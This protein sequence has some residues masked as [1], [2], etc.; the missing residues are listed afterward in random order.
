MLWVWCIIRCYRRRSSL[1]YFFKKS[2]FLIAFFSL[3][4]T[5]LYLFWSFLRRKARITISFSWLYCIP[6]TFLL[7]SFS[8]LKS[9]I[10]AH[11]KLFFAFCF[12]FINFKTFWSFVENNFI[13]FH[14]FSDLHSSSLFISL[15]LFIQIEKIIGIRIKIII[16]LFRW[17]TKLLN[18][19]R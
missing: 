11:N 4:E 1:C 14:C 12:A 7:F 9:S 18:F 15:H 2:L 6:N 16:L 5:I 13:N 17:K 3:I 8:H 10:K 19:Q